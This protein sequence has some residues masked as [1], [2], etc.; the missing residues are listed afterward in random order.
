MNDNLY[1]ECQKIIGYQFKDVNLLE[2]SLTHS[3]YANENKQ[4]H[5]K[6]KK[7]KD[8]ER[9]EFL[10]DAVLELA[11][12]NNIFHAYPDMHEGKMSKYRA[13][14][15]CEPTLAA[16]AR[17]FNLP[18]FLLLG[19]GEE[20]TGG[21]D[22]DSIISDALEALIGAIYLD[23]GMKNATK[24]INKFILNDIDYKRLFYDSKSSLQEVI[25]AQGKEVVYTDISAE[26]PQ[27]DKTFTVEVE[28]EGL[29]KIRATGNTKKS[30]QQNAAYKALLEL[31]KKGMCG[32]GKG[33]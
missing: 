14:I 24:F 12:S 23:G 20:A 17:E 18:K 28:T 27:H 29:F 21:R 30:A 32:T 16:C 19:K 3:S 15:V 22:R 7:P 1:D 11:T 26:G 6:G 2:L 4:G 8:N 5:V 13:S 31:K 33:K 10:G 25:Q 9:L